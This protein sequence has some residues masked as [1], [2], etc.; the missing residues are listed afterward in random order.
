MAKIISGDFIVPQKL[1]TISATKVDIPAAQQVTHLQFRRFASCPICNLHIHSFIERH[2]DLV[3]NGIQEI[4]VFHSTQDEMLKY[5]SDVPFAMIADPAK[6]LYKAFGV[7]SSIMSV[8][9]P[10]AWAPAVT[11][12]LK[13]KQLPYEKGQGLFGLPADFLIAK[14]GEVIAVKY[15]AHADDHWEVDEVITQ[16]RQLAVV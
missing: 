12:L 4:V 1:Q 8:I 11:G 14:T 13:F 16:A 15:G 10:A 9:N 3:A 7:E 5:G 6:E 2:L